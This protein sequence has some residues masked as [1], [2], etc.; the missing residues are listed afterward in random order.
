M[1]KKALED[2]GWC[3]MRQTRHDGAI[4][5]SDVFQFLIGKLAQ[6]REQRYV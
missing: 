4:Q 5:P 1:K 3:E 6:L 2:E